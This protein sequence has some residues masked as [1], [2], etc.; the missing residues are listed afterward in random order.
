MEN[1]IMT[2]ETAVMRK[3]KTIFPTVSIRAFPEGNLRG[4]TFFT[5][6]LVNMRVT[7]DIGSKIASAIVVK[8]ER[9]PELEAAYIWRQARMTLAAKDPL[10]AIWNFNWFSPSNS[11]ASRTCSST[12]FS[13]RSMF[14]F[15]LS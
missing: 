11:L 13:H 10:T 8:S 1:A 5:A 6:R 2:H 12:G 14:S 3:Q 15:W 9:E 4:F 7:L